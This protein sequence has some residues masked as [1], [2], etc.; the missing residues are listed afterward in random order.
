MEVNFPYILRMVPAE[1][2]WHEMG[3]N[4]FDAA[5]FWLMHG[6][7]IIAVHAHGL[8]QPGD[9]GP[10]GTGMNGFS[11]GQNLLRSI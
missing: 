3:I 5:L 9:T 2:N 1:T 7:V 6:V 4:H 8:D 10:Q 11:S